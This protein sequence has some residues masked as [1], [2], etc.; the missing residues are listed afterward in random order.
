MELIKLRST[1]DRSVPTVH[2]SKLT[3]PAQAIKELPDDPFQAAGIFSEKLNR[4]MDKV[5]HRYEKQNDTI[6]R[7]LALIALPRDPTAADLKTLSIVLRDA[8]PLIEENG[9]FQLQALKDIAVLL[10]SASLQI[11]DGFD[12]RYYNIHSHHGHDLLKIL[13]RKPLSWQT[14]RLINGAELLRKELGKYQGGQGLAEPILSPEPEIQEILDSVT[15][16]IEQ[17]KKVRKELNINHPLRRYQILAQP[18]YPSFATLFLTVISSFFYMGNFYLLS[19]AAKDYAGHLNMPGSF[20]GLL[21]GLNWAAAV[22]FAFV[23][24]FW[25]NYQFKIPT[26]ICAFIVVLGNLLYFLA[27]DTDMAILLFVGRLMIG[28]GGPRVIN[29]RYIAVYVAVKARTRWNAAYVAGSILGMACGPFA[30][31]GLFYANF[32]FLGFT[33]NGMNS[34]AFVMVIIWLIY[35]LCCVFF[36]EEPEIE[37]KK[38]AEAAQDHEDDEEVNS[39]LPTIMALWALFFP[40]MVQESFIIA[41]PIAAEISFDWT[42]ADVGLYLAIISFLVAPIHIV[43][44]VTSSWIEDRQFIMFAKAIC[45]VGAL[46][47]IDFGSM[48]LL[49][50]VIGSLVLYYATNIADPV[51]TSLTSKVLPKKIARG[52]FNAGMLA[53]LAGSLGRATGGVAVAVAGYWGNEGLENNL[54]IPLTVMCVI[55]AVLMKL[56]YPMMVPIDVG[57]SPKSTA[58]SNS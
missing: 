28:I 21:T 43:I 2:T 51:S 36:F 14:R 31:A 37:K 32:T 12:E 27:W 6:E 23:Y 30:A 24:S 34:P 45:I 10:Q 1:I 33:V 47:L 5:S 54:F 40:K 7:L 11:Q 17:I 48:P 19:V 44:G 38:P 16:Q 15:K 20:S 18:D 50:Y 8:A 42:V 52:L 9:K 53:T 49:Q 26:V 39:W 41:A 56:V 3:K 55:S 13:S 57:L 35:G 46:L 29:R 25:S 4:A 22:V 58:K